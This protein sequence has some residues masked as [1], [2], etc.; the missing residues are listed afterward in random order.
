[1]RY[2]TSSLVILLALTLLTILPSS[3]IS[4]NKA[5]AFNQTVASTN[6]LPFGPASD[7]LI[8][9]YYSDFSTMFTAFTTGGANGIDITDWPMFPS[10]VG[11]LC[12]TAANPDFFCGSQQA[13]FGLDQVDI[14]HHNNFLGVAQFTPRTTLSVSATIASTAAGCSTGFGSATVSLKNQETGVVDPEQKVNNMTL[15]QVLSGGVLGTPTTVSGISGTG[16]YTFPCV[17][18]GNYLLTNNAYANCP[19][20]A[21]CTILIG[22]ATSNQVTFNSNWG[23]KSPQKFTLAGTLT[24]MAIAEL[25]DKP[26]YILASPLQGNAICTDI[27][28]S[29]PQGFP[30]GYCSTG[31]ISNPT[32]QPAPDDVLTQYCQY[33]TQSET[34]QG[35][36]AANQLNCA[37]LVTAIKGTAPSK[38]A[39]LLN[40][41]AIG[42]PQVGWGAPGTNTGS[43]DVYPSEQDV[44]AACDLFVLAGFPVTPSGNTCINVAGAAQGT[45][46]KTSYPHNTLPSGKQIIVY[47]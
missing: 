47:G 35:I 5:H 8:L 21:A 7:Q 23:S 2:T 18:A 6:W 32:P 38:S 41:T 30:A 36:A 15:T 33:I 17:V 19:T 42:S 14:N 1:M 9:S 13:A 20:N 46:T 37:A 27:Y 24:R 11:S 3:Y 10:N 16:V 43:T 4:I 44:R 26:Q 40:M 39:Y 31:G 29:E 12:N 34:S 25:L 45:A 28:A 22:S